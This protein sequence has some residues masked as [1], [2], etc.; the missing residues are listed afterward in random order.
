MWLLVLIM[1]SSSFYF[2]VFF[3]FAARRVL[4]IHCVWMSSPCLHVKSLCVVVM[5]D[6]WWL[7]H[8]IMHVCHYVWSHKSILCSMEPQIDEEPEIVHLGPNNPSLLTRQRYHRSEDIWN[9][10]VKYLV[11]TTTLI[12]TLSLTFSKFFQSCISSSNNRYNFYQFCRT[13]A[14]LHAVVALKRWQ[15]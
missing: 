9:G 15:T 3:K 2:I 4:I 8:K 10:E 13:R 5:P 7:L 6:L 12:F 1:P 11:L 14:H